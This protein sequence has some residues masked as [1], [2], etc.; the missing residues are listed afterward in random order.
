MN[1]LE[2][3]YKE[4]VIPSLMKELG[5]ENPMKLPK[6]E[7][8]TVN[9]CCGREATANSK[10]VN[11]AVEEL[12]TISGQKPVITRAKKAIANFKL[13]EG[14]PLGCAVT[15]RQER[16]WAFL[17]RLINV[18]MPRV[19][20]FKGV[21]PK[22]FDGRGN[23]NMG[24]K[25]QIVFP[26]INYDKVDKLRGMNITICTSAETDEQSRALLTGLGFPFRKN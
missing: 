18:G 21:S 24:L 25:E 7:K 3:K 15:L 26:E 14:M 20:D 5:I 17:D 2:K 6:L 1:R 19:R 22:G 8:I 23:Y 11:T 9:I 13:R 10:V 16:M 4:D 12:A